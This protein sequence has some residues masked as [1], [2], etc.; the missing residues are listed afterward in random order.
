MKQIL[1]NVKQDKLFLPVNSFATESSKNY[2]S[3]K[4]NFLDNDWKDCDLIL[5]IFE[6][7]NKQITKEVL[8]NENCVT[9]KPQVLIGPYFNVCLIGYNHSINQQIPTNYVNVPINYIININEQNVVETS[10]DKIEKSIIK[11]RL[12]EFS[13]LVFTRNNGE[14]LIVLINDTTYY[15]GEFSSYEEL[16]AAFPTGNTGDYAYVNTREEDGD[17]LI[18][19]TWDKDS[20]SWKEYSTDKYLSSKTFELFK[21]NYQQT[22]NTINDK[23][24]TNIADINSLK[25]GKVDK[26]DG[27]GLSTND[28]SNEDKIFV[29]L[30]KDSSDFVGYG[31]VDKMVLIEGTENDTQEIEKLLLEDY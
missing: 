23:L 30:A 20:N 26:E 4:F 13:R 11:A 24:I 2:L 18:K 28:Y 31:V 9:V 5:A 1:L 22:I 21:I 17:L 8:D 29:Q 6:N 16:I 14:E 15:K 19:Y 12:D 27:K 3:L 7:S 10:Y 25:T